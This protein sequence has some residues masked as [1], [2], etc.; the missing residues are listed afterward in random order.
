MRIENKEEWQEGGG[1]V[2][3]RG[4]GSVCICIE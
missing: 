3:G 1:G 2:E 4:G